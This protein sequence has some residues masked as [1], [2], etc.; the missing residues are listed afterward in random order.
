MKIP[1]SG[2]YGM[3]G[4]KEQKLGIVEGRLGLVFLRRICRTGGMWPGCDGKARGC[5][6]Y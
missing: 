2:S 1:A 4:T 3:R 5:L 6:K